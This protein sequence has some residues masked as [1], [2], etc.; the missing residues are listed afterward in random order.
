VKFTK[1]YSVVSI[2]KTIEN[3]KQVS[4][5][6]AFTTIKKALDQ[7]AER[8]GSIVGVDQS[9]TGVTFYLTKRPKTRQGRLD[10][11]K[12]VDRLSTLCR[13]RMASYSPGIIIGRT[14]NQLEFKQRRRNATS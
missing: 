7:A 14:G 2:S 4:S 8:V 10:W 6:G 9:R 13:E 5:T 12:E 1:K 11:N 3:K